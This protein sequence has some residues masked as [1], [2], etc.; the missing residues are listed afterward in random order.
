MPAVPI[1]VLPYIRGIQLVL[2]SYEGYTKGKRREADGLIRDE[3]NVL[4][5]ERAITC[6]ISK[7]L[8]FK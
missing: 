5:Q 8:R 3:S 2:S 7:I 1:E 4:A 6:L